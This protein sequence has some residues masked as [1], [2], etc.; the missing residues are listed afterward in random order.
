M[1]DGARMLDAYLSE[2]RTLLRNLP[3]PEVSEIEAELRSH[4][5]D[6]GTRGG[7]IESEVAATLA[8]L[9]SPAALASLYDTDR[10]LVRAGR[11]RS[12]WL[13]LWSLFR[14]AAVSVAGIC[15]LIPV[16]GGYLVAAS[17]FIAALVKPFAPDRVGLWRL[18]NDEFSLRLGLTATVPP[19]GQELLGWAIVPL[20][21]IVGSGTFLLAVWFGRWA[22]RR[23]R[24]IPLHPTP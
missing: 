18:S 3:E 16:I 11:S 24:R 21:L 17:F 2:L 1:G 4:V 22:I 6:S 7:L 5:R 9:G 20:G 8:R 15:V 14:W 12:P 23:F 19:R 10:L 13:L